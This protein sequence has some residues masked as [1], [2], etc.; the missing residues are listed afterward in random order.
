MKKKTE[1]TQEKLSSVIKFT[2]VRKSKNG[3]YMIWI[4]KNVL[5]L[6]PNFLKAVDKKT[7]KAS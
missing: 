6:H 1:K 3:S 4:G 2:S 7:K 5:F